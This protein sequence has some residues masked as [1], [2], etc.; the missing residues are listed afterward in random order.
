M[1]TGQV[2]A[3]IDDRDFAVALQQAKADVDAARAAVNGKQAQLEA[4]Q[5]V[6]DSARATV[7]VD[8]ANAG[9]AE[10]DDRRYATLATSGYGSQ[11]NAQ[12]A[13]SRIAA[14]RAAIARDTAALATALKQVDLLNAELAQAQAALAHDE[15]V[16][17][18]A[19]LNLSYTVI[20]SPVDG[21]S[22][23]GRCASAST[24]RPAPS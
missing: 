5:S 15:A 2:L 6:I 13:A 3:R 16:Q 12:Q 4:Q 11:Q 23:T 8:Q 1:K 20:T 18:Q 7:S 10:Q 9:F 14:A 21:A 22:A 17:R 19:E 24:C